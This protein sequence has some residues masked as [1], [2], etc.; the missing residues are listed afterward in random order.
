MLRLQRT[1]GNTAVTRL[2]LQRNQES[3]ELMIKHLGE[4]RTLQLKG[5]EIKVQD[6]LAASLDEAIQGDLV[7]APKEIEALDKQWFAESNLE[8]TKERTAGMQ[9]LLDQMHQKRANLGSYNDATFIGA[10]VLK[11]GVGKLEDLM[12]S[13]TLVD[14]PSLNDKTA[15]VKQSLAGGAYHLVQ[16][17]GL[18]SSVIKNTLVTME[19]AGQLEYLR[20]AGLPNDKYAILIEVHYYRNRPTSKTKLHK[21]TLGETL[22]VNLSFTNKNKILGPE[23]IVNPASDPSYDEFVRQKLPGV[24]VE[25][26]EAFKKSFK[27]EKMIKATVLEP[28]SVVAFV[29]EA[30]HH[31]TPTPGPRTA[32]AAGLKVAMANVYG[33]EYKDAENAYKGYKGAS[34]VSL[35]TFAS[36]FKNP[37]AKAHSGDWWELLEKLPTLNDTELKRKDLEAWLPTYFKARAEEILEQA[38]T[39]FT[40]VSLAIAGGK[41]I[42][43]PVR[44]ASEKPLK[45]QMS[46][47]KL[48]ETYQAKA[49]DSGKRSFFRTWVRA[50][51]KERFG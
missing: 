1:L 51:P 2:L 37:T 48:G 23:Y 50:V 32:S 13:A 8:Q 19:K 5:D 41:Y 21:D 16:K 46:M 30:I 24:F 20:K 44:Q 14:L 12:A 26:L 31:K 39:D 45:R 33:D 47:E 35:W 18:A 34:R 17:K 49:Q 29:D 7:A 43:V 15:K 40:G 10:I 11:E 25:D 22:F 3:Q 4:P 6:D 27:E 38:A 42:T 28:N 36:Y 9:A